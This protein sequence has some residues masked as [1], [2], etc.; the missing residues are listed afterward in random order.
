MSKTN[1]K[2]K[3]E[4]SIDGILG[5]LTIHGQGNE[6]KDSI[7]EIQELKQRLAAYESLGSLEELKKE[8]EQLLQA[9]LSLK[10]EQ[11][12]IEALIKK[13]KA[14]TGNLKKEK[15]QIE[16]SYRSLSL[17]ERDKQAYQPSTVILEYCE[18]AEGKRKLTIHLRE[19]EY[20]AILKASRYLHHTSKGQLMDT[21]TRALRF[22]I[23]KNYYLEAEQEVSCKAIYSVQGVLEGMGFSQEEIEK[24][25]QKPSVSRE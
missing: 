25:I 23:P 9:I 16:T 19:I 7:Q 17:Y 24:W 13:V 15:E 12:R 8:R 22:Y 20:Q 14:E 2:K 18:Q 6:R 10:E 5:G 3:I 11:G 4:A 21:I 1:S